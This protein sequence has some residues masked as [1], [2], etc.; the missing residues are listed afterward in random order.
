MIL[1]DWLLCRRIC[2]GLGRVTHREQER[3]SHWWNHVSLS[4][5]KSYVHSC[6]V[7]TQKQQVV[8]GFGFRLPVQ[9]FSFIHDFR[10]RKD[11]RK[12]RRNK[13]EKEK[14]WYKSTF[15]GSQILSSWSTFEFLA[16]CAPYANAITIE[17]TIG[18]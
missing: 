10:D 3:W 18:L 16:S 14:S 13:R 7:Q 5:T 17:L 11:E 8:S 6:S 15:M 2:L 9:L 1:G 4:T 12:E